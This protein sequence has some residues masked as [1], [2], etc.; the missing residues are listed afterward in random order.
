MELLDIW[1]KAWLD[2][3]SERP[4]YNFADTSGWRMASMRRNPEDGDW[5]F[6][7]GYTFLANWA[8]WRNTHPEWE[9]ATLGGQLAIEIEASPVING[10]EV[11]MFIDR[12]F[13]N[14]ETG[15]YAIIDLKT[16]KTTPGSPLQLAFYKYGIKSIFNV[17][18]NLGYYWMARKG[19]LSQPFNLA[20]LGD[21]QIE[22]LVDMFDRARKDKLFLPNFDSCNMC[23]F[24]ASCVWYQA[25]EQ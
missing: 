16:G 9:I 14:K 4:E 23:G 7:H 15:Q 12:V 20:G 1:K 10:V 22:T 3:Q 6:T 11:K 19:E 17:D 21:S 24:T 25:K 8:E 2:T 13:Y 5:W 18:V